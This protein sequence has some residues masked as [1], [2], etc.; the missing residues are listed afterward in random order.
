MQETERGTINCQQILI[1][2]IVSLTSC[3]NRYFNI[4]ETPVKLC[5][6]FYVEDFLTVDRCLTQKSCYNA[7]FKSHIKN[8]FKLTPCCK[9]AYFL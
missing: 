3:H 4:A 9:K 1:N 5:A 2:Y 6:I 8:H 7:V